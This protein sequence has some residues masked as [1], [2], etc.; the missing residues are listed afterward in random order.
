MIYFL[1]SAVPIVPIRCVA[2]MGPR[3]EFPGCRYTDFSPRIR[4]SF[5]NLIF[6]SVFEAFFDAGTEFFSLSTKNMKK[7]RRIF[8]PKKSSP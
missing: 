4:K 1:Y 3:P 5:Y 2:P 6:F 8:A 7:G